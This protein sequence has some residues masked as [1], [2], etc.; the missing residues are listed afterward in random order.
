MIWINRIIAIVSF[1]NKK[2]LHVG[3]GVLISSDLVLTTAAGI[4][5][6]E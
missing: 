4:F 5:D 3:S 6:K 1:R 2:A